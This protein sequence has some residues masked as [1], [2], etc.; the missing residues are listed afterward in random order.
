[1]SRKRVHI[2]STV[3]AA[4]VSKAGGTYTIKEVCG[5]TDDIVM[6]AVLYPADQLA[7]SI[8]SLEGKPAPAGHPKNGDGHYISA[9]SGDALLNAYMGAVCV[10]AR[11]E[12][13]RSLVD[14]VIN[15]AQAKA[16]PDG[17]KLIER[18]D[19]AISGADAEP[20]HVSTGL[21]TI[22][23]TA[24][25][26][27]RGKKY[28]RIAT[29]IQYDHLAILLHEQGAGKPSDGVGM[30]LNSEGKPEPVDVVTA[31]ADPDDL[32][33]KG[34]TGWIRK[35]LGNVDLSFGQ[36]SSGL[37]KALPQGCWLT[38]VYDKYAIYADQDNAYWRQDYSVGSDGSVAWQGQP[39]K[40]AR[41]VT[42]EAVS[43]HQ[44][45]GDQM[46]ET[47]LA[48]L[49]AAG[50]QTAGMDDA[51]LLAAY[52]AHTVKA[53]AA[54]L[55]EVKGK[56]SAIENAAR[57][58]E[59]AEVTALATELAVNS[60]LTVEDLKKLGKARLNELKAKA[61]PVTPGAGQAGKGDEFKGYSINAVLDAAAK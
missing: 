56:L 19:N 40:V 27:S 16:H 42:Y 6:N 17:V 34:L 31:N 46:R 20:I 14:V 21:L 44:T 25:G 2:L 9:L 32:R 54:E 18:L 51:A 15:E 59:E 13:G 1:M 60:A 48:A 12:G 30:F 7:N 8:D 45:K 24:N 11:H 3:N 43:N 5:A 39:V 53:T 38:E 28:S 33:F 4:N 36:I 29:N 57:A 23:V 52:N 37:Y 55:T 10:N 47:I 49:N 58:A 35:L 50:V 61:A 41:K 26:E 22:P